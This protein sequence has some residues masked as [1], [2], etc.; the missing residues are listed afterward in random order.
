M[1]SPYMHWAK[2]TFQANVPYSLTNSGVF[3]LSLRELEVTLDDLE[4]SGAS[5]YGYPPLLSALARYCGVEPDCIVAATGTSGANHLA[6][7][8]IIQPGDE[9]LIEQP[10]YDPILC[11]ASNLGAVVRRFLRPADEGFRL[12][13]NAVVAALTPRT[14]LIVLTNLH[15]PTS[16]LASSEELAAIGEMA[17]GNGT[18]VLVDEVYLPTL[19]E[20]VLRSSFHLGLPFVVT[21]SLTKAYGLSGLRCGWILAEPDLARRMWQLNDLFGVIPAHAAERLS[22]AA[23]AQ[24]DRI[25]ARA[26]AP[27]DTN[28]AMVHEF[29]SSR[30]DLAGGRTHAGT[31][32]FPRLLWGDVQTLFELARARGTA[33]VPGAFFEAPEH[34]RIGFGCPTE[35]LRGGLDR[36][37]AALDELG[38]PRSLREGCCNA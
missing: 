20:P 30:A 38:D 24:V 11:A 32:S 23:L 12:D 21:C 2:T 13:P 17:R 1:S 36:L 9:V 29:L 19:F 15:N 5:Y 33:V 28:S 34:F 3:S 22:C 6:M 25:A 8:A 27:L 14:K 16:C 4:I 7:A 26:R 18:R 31:V 35:T 37:A 10:A